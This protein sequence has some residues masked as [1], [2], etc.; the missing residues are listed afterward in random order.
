[1][2]SWEWRMAVGAVM[3]LVGSGSV[4]ASALGSSDSLSARLTAREVAVSL[5]Y[6]NVHPP[7]S[8]RDRW[9]AMDK[10][11]HVGGS[12]LWTLASQYVLVAK[13][14]ASEKTAL[15]WSVASGIAIGLA[16]EGYDWRLGPTR[17]FSM[18]DLVADGVG[19]ALAVGIILI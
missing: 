10:A 1:M 9:W 18:K 16:K 14:G 8:P 4:P 7:L 12:A 15:P 17:H 6:A 19:I 3:M 11:K 13:V 2:R 5:R